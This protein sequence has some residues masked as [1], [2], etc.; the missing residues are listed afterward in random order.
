MFDIPLNTVGLSG[1]ESSQAINCTGTDNEN[2]RTKLCTLNHKPRKN[3]TEIHQ[4]LTEK[5]KA[6]L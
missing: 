6:I 2:G 4:K 5:S 1:D 3:N